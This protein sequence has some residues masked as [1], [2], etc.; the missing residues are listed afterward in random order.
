MGAIRLR[1][2]YRTTEGAEPHA[3]ARGEGDGAASTEA[4]ADAESAGEF[5]DGGAGES[6]VAVIARKPSSN[7]TGDCNLVW[8]LFSGLLFYF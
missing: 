2:L 6:K 4:Y 8:M 1:C 3:G 5:D 7:K